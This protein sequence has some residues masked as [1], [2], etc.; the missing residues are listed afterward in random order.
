[1]MKLDLKHSPTQTTA[2]HPSMCFT[3]I[4]IAF[5]F[6]VNSRPSEVR[7]LDTRVRQTWNLILLVNQ[8]IFA[9]KIIYLSEAKM[10]QLNKG[11]NISLWGRCLCNTAPGTQE[12]LNRC[13][14]CNSRTVITLFISPL[15]YQNAPNFSSFSGH[16]W[17][18]K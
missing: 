4:S 15:V 2:S 14:L 6:L 10:I 11:S 1:M 16:S 13:Y 17:V 9:R 7:N 5:D 12:T 18:C 3:L 8:M